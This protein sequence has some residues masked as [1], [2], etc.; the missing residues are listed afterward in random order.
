M[1]HCFMFYESEALLCGKVVEQLSPQMGQTP[2]G[3]LLLESCRTEEVVIVA[4]LEW[5][6]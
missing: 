5:V 4:E 1:G 2:L 6:S 3:V